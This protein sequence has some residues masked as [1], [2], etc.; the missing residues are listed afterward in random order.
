MSVSHAA[1]DATH[2]ALKHSTGFSPEEKKLLSGL[3]G[4]DRARAE[5]QLSLQKQQETVAF[6]SKV[7][8]NDTTM[9]VLN[10]MK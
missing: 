6:I 3:S 8:K 5:A 4:A 1:N 10:N 2:A 7:L 9:Q